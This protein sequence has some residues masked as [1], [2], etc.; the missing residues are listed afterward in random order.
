M[1]HSIILTG[2]GSTGK[3][4]LGKALKSEFG[5]PL[6]EEYART[7]M[8]HNGASY[9]KN[10]VIFMEKEQR[11]RALNSY[12]S[13]LEVQIVDS[14]VLTFI[15]WM[16]DKF[17]ACPSAWIDHFKGKD[18][19]TYFLCQVDIPWVKDPYRVDENRRKL[20]FDK[21]KYYL[22]LYSKQ[23]IIIKGSFETRYKLARQYILHMS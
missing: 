8:E 7:W 9:T 10:D 14:D 15:I 21:Y 20:L 11:R 19:C 6:I 17:G 5:I 4:S 22:D 23:Y 13:S 12:D 3:S 16:E 18:S 1:M 2:P